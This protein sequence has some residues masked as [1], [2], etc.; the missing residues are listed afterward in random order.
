MLNYKKSSILL[1]SII[2]AGYYISGFF[3]HDPVIGYQI[4]D[5]YRYHLPTIQLFANTPFLTAIKDYPSATFPL[6]HVIYAAVYRYVTADVHLLR[7]IN[8]LT[9]ILT[10]VLLY[11]L[12]SRTTDLAKNNILLI[13]MSFLSSPF[14]RGSGFALTTDALPFLFIALSFLA[15]SRAGEAKWSSVT[16]SCL[17]AFAAFYTR[18]F[19]FWVPA[20]V[21]LKSINLVEK[22][23]RPFLVLMNVLLLV[24]AVYL[25]RVWKGMTPPSFQAEH[26]S[27]NALMVLP[28]IFANIPF[29]YIPVYLYKARQ[30]RSPLKKYAVMA[31]VCIPLSIL[32]V[33]AYMKGHF[34]IQFVNGG[35]FPKTFSMLFGPYA[36]PLFLF[37]GFWGLATVVYYLVKNITTNGYL[38]LIVAAL[39]LSQIVF[40]KYVDPLL[41]M[42]MFVLYDEKINGQFN[43][44]GFVWL[45]PFLE[46][47]LWCGA[48]LYYGLT[49]TN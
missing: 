4:K 20:I 25:V 1:L 31:V 11:I 34:S 48:F 24:P 49:V 9:I 37:W 15:L 43:R 29:Y 7:L 10:A 28:F 35:F 17:F 27:A 3:L 30:S 19:Y 26:Q 46:L 5:E 33:W 8:L 36:S 22:K 21:F 45:Y 40:Q 38:A 18:Q 42:M 14:L 44:S 13:I 16:L 23:F 6:Y 41:I 2:I 32:Y 47:A 39:S 12:F